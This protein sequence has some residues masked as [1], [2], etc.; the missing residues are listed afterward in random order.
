MSSFVYIK[1]HASIF[2]IKSTNTTKNK[3]SMKNVRKLF[4]YC[5]YR[6]FLKCWLSWNWPGSPDHE[7]SFSDIQRNIWNMGQ[8]SVRSLQNCSKT[9]S[10]QWY[11]QQTLPH[12][13]SSSSI[14]SEPKVSAKSQAAA[15]WAT[16]LLL[17][18]LE[19]D[20]PLCMWPP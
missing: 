15:L 3:Q 19:D 7:Q 10:A 17:V 13:Q 16:F 9:F 12:Q 5:R 4:I 8:Y 11:H 1:H 20:N 2:I 14:W 6:K 18:I